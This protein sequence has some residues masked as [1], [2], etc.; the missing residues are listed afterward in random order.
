M[1]DTLKVICLNLRAFLLN[2]A[3]VF[4]PRKAPPPASPA[5]VLFIRID[6]IGDLVLSTPA[7]KAVKERY[8][9]AEL[10]ALVSPVTA[11]L[12]AAAPGV[13]RVI[14]WDASK[15]WAG[16]AGTIKVLRDLHFDLAIDP[17]AD[18]ELRTALIAFLSGA[19]VRAGYQAYGRGIFFN[20]PVAPPQERA[21]FVKDAFGVLKALGIYAPVPDPELF[22]SKEAQGGARKL[23]AESGVAEKD[24]LVAIHPGG[25]YPSQ[26]WLPER[27]AEVISGLVSRYNAKILLIGGAGERELVKKI[28]DSVT[29]ALSE[30]TIIK[31]IDL[32]TDVLCA[33][34]R[35]SRLFIG[36]NS[37][38]LHMAGALKI[39]SI[40]TM[41]P[42]DPVR[43]SPLGRDQVVLRSDLKCSPCNKGSCKSH[44]CMND[45]T[46]DMMMEGVESLL[47]KQGIAGKEL[48]HED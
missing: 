21:H 33:L 26:R 31:A 44:E 45:L 19:K 29:G 14:I 41:G 2:V 36:N 7:L 1:R 43:W 37:G 38:P 6:R 15:G 8:P 11:P 13:S 23:L 48:S 24:L 40:S 32:R 34:I 46:V 16:L 18:Y 28:A 10:T 17:Y 4:F 25:Y 3:G 39:P 42:T 5:R 27:F 20:V 9:E 30:R 22:I 12:L 47:S 35:R